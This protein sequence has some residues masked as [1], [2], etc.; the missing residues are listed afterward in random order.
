MPRFRRHDPSRRPCLETAVTTVTELRVG[1]R[2]LRKAT[3]LNLPSQDVFLSNTVTPPPPTPP[4]PASAPPCWHLWQ[5]R[6]LSR[7]APAK[8]RFKALPR[9][10]QSVPPLLSA[11][12]TFI[13][14][15]S[16]VR[17]V[18]TNLHLCD[19]TQSMAKSF[20]GLSPHRLT[21]VGGRKS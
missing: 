11:M 2:R 4:P 9:I 14:N 16:F 3:N 8:T 13:R 17:P 21:D 1:S 19:S 6:P 12:E 7:F 10:E 15:Q 20:P 5:R 18:H